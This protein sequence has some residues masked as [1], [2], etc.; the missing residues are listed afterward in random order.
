MVGCLRPFLKSEEQHHGSQSVPEE[1]QSGGLQIDSGLRWNGRVLQ[2]LFFHF[3][4]D[5]TG[6]FG[7]GVPSSD[8]R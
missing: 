6:R 7:A 1:E 2:G 8:L 4:W 5:L 3:H